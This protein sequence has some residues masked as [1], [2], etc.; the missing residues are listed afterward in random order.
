MTLSTKRRRTPGD[1]CAHRSR[2]PI[3]RKKNAT[4]V[5]LNCARLLFHERVKSERAN[6]RRALRLRSIKAITCRRAPKS[7]RIKMQRLM[8]PF[9]T[10]FNLGEPRRFNGARKTTERAPSIILLCLHRISVYLLGTSVFRSPDGGSFSCAPAY[11][12]DIKQ[13]GRFRCASRGSRG[14]HADYD[15]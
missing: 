1:Q 3:R 7:L 15:T 9:H 13:R 14:C 4:P 8:T 5:K 12:G 2:H 10:E 11:T 6:L